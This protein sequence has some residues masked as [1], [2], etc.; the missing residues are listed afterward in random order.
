M[1]SRGRTLDEDC[2]QSRYCLYRA[3]SAA[4]HAVLARVRPF[5]LARAGES[6]PIRCSH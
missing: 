6:P 1:F 3:S 2:A 5:Y 4:I